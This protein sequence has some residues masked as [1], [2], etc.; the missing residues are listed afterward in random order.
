MTSAYRRWPWKVCLF[1]LLATAMSYLDRQALSI[2]APVIQQETHLDNAR[3]GLLVSA[4]FYSYYFGHLAVRWVLDRFLTRV[5]YATFVGLWSI[6][7]AMGGLARGFGSLF[8]ARLKRRAPLC[9]SRR[10]AWRGGKCSWNELELS[11]VEIAPVNTH[12]GR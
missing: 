10:T 3:L 5:T 8:A 12:D 11:G 2:A 4:F 6:S 9:A 1:F 7:Q